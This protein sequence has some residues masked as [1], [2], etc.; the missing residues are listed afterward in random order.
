MEPIHKDIE[1]LHDN[2]HAENKSMS[3][4]SQQL[5]TSNELPSDPP[6]DDNGG[7]QDESKEG[8]EGDE[9]RT[10]V[11]EGETKSK[12]GEPNDITVHISISESEDQETEN[13][14]VQNRQNGEVSDNQTERSESDV[15]VGVSN[16]NHSQNS[17]TE[18]K[19]TYSNLSEDNV[20]NPTS[21]PVALDEP[22]EESNIDKNK[23]KQKQKLSRHRK[24]RKLP[25]TGSHMTTLVKSHMN[26]ANK[27]NITND[28]NN[29]RYNRNS[30]T[31]HHKHKKFKKNSFNHAMK[32]FK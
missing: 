23:R 22:K 13:I 28:S 7:N 21:S 24:K 26:E 18:P 19:N 4:L 5:E 1:I 2:D 30:A 20:V 14:P 31:D 17:D 32:K 29:N 25:I 11:K 15:S 3:E 12:K 10:T 9:H 16:T 27:N 8:H 6:S